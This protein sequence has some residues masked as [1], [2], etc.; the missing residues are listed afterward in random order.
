MNDDFPLDFGVRLFCL[1]TTETVDTTVAEGV[2]EVVDKVEVS[3]DSLSSWSESPRESR[4]ADSIRFLAFCLYLDIL[5][6]EI[7]Y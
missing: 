6:I 7:G 4:F 3:K 2:T 1:L 5:E